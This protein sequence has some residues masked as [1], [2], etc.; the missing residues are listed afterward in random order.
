M[1]RSA[2]ALLLPALSLG[3]CHISKNGADT[4]DNVSVKASDNGSVSFNLPFAKGEVQIPRRAFEN[5]QLDIDGVKMIPGGSVRGFTMEGGDK[6]ATVHLAFSAPKSPQEV[7]GYFLEQFKQH[8]DAATQSGNAVSG[9]TRDGDDFSIHVEP[10]AQG[11][12][13]TVVIQSKD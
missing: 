10:A 13:G 7:S 2:L 4:D 9:K 1:T 12:V 6:G 11:S 3:A 8:G 5:G